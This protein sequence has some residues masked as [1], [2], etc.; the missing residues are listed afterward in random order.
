[1]RLLLNN[2]L[3]FRSFTTSRLWSWARFG[4]L[5]WYGVRCLTFSEL[6]LIFNDNRC[7]VGVFLLSLYWRWSLLGIHLG[8]FF[9]LLFGIEVL[10]GK[11]HNNW[12]PLLRFPESLTGGWHTVFLTETTNTD[13]LFWRICFSLWLF[14]KLSRRRAH[15]KWITTL[16]SNW[17]VLQFGKSTVLRSSRTWILSLMH[18]LFNNGWLILLLLI[19]LGCL[20]FRLSR[21]IFLRFFT[22]LSILISS[23]AAK[24]WTH[25]VVQDIFVAISCLLLARCWIFILKS[26]MLVEVIFFKSIAFWSK[27]TRRFLIIQ[28][29]LIHQLVKLELE[30]ILFRYRSHWWSLLF[31][32]L[33]YIASFLN[34]TWPK[35]FIISLDS[36]TISHVFIP[37]WRTN[38]VAKLT[39][40][41]RIR[42]VFLCDLFT[43][44]NVVEWVLVCTLSL[45]LL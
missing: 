2:L 24:H 1:M 44:T 21:V 8:F 20:H 45:Q 38:A 9:E 40:F 10:S 39:N 33:G 29:T 15:L 17:H 36:L 28:T 30:I 5:T 12:L 6:I 18:S 13:T 37:W 7:I 11:F 35:S 3:G 26:S 41:T 23:E 19:G 32:L 43:L 4:S 25:S 16:L 27:L 22:R 31:W 34:A 42:K 14:D